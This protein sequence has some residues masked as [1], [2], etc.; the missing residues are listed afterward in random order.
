M[1]GREQDLK[2][3]VHNLGVPLLKTGVLKLPY[4]FST[5]LQLNGKFN[6]EYLQRKTRSG[7]SDIS[8]F[9]EIW[10]TNAET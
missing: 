5:T 7:Q 6:G 2:M 8:K 4:R 9:Y 3:R 1:F 10:S